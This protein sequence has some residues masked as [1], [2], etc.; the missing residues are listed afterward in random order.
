MA[1]QRL[2]PWMLM[3]KFG[4]SKLFLVLYAYTDLND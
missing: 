2:K 3:C 4:K 1:E